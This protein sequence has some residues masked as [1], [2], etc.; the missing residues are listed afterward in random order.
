[1]NMEQFWWDNWGREGVLVKKLVAVR[2]LVGT[3]AVG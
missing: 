2:D 3:A 1:M